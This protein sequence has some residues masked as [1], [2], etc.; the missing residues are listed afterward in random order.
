MSSAP[1]IPFAPW[2]SPDPTVTPSIGTGSGQLIA[3]VPVAEP[4]SVGAPPV[5]PSFVR[6]VEPGYAGMVR[7]VRS[8]SGHLKTSRTRSAPRPR[9]TLE[10]VGLSLSQ[11][12]ALWSWMF[13][14]VGG[15][16]TLQ[17][18][19]LEIDGPGTSSTTN[20]RMFRT[21]EETHVWR[22][23][24]GEHVYRIGPVECE[25]IK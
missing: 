16:G 19:T 20:L 10:W 4:L 3:L 21:P 7:S 17:A 22:K 2:R 18:F 5:L 6:A 24:T 9:F 14:D 23:R 12:N 25:E 1:H 11:R 8:V 15:G 13:G